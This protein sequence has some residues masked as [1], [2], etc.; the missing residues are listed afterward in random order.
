[1]NTVDLL[2]L[3]HSDDSD[4]DTADV[5]LKLLQQLESAEKQRPPPVEYCSVGVQVSP[6][7]IP[8]V[9]VKSTGIQPEKP[10]RRTVG[11][12]YH[13]PKQPQPQIVQKTSTR[14]LPVVIE[15]VQAYYEDPMPSYHEPR[16]VRSP[17]PTPTPSPAPDRPEPTPTPTSHRPG[18]EYPDITRSRRSPVA[19]SHS[20]IMPAPAPFSPM[21]MTAVKSASLAS[22]RTSESVVSDHSTGR[23][24]WSRPTYD[25]PTP[26]R[27]VAPSESRHKQAIAELRRAMEAVSMEE[28]LGG[29]F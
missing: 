9:K 23:S 7:E 12:Q 16:P 27:P 22:T 24:D 18:I 1:M 4:D 25:M 5:L 2:R 14:V 26:P 13:P 15:R 11:I 29:F 28:R 3:L 17:S 20:P 8:P 6:P 21:A 10:R 19:T